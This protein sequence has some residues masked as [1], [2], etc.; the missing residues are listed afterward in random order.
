ME[1]LKDSWGFS[2][3][4]VRV[5]CPARIASLGTSRVVLAQFDRYVRSTDTRR[6]GIGIAKATLNDLGAQAAIASKRDGFLTNAVTLFSWWVEVSRHT[7]LRQRQQ[8]QFLGTLETVNGTP[9]TFYMAYHAEREYRKQR[10]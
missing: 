9:W 8:I 5:F 2:I 7:A 4:Y 3:I 10:R 1:N 6:G